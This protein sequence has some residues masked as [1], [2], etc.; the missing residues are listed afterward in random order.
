MR[1]VIFCF[2]VGNLHATLG[3]EVPYLI[4]ILS[5]NVK[6]Y[7]QLREVIK[8]GEDSR[9]LL[10]ALNEGIDNASQLLEALPIENEKVLANLA[11]FQEASDWVREV[12]GAIPK[13]SEGALFKL[14]DDT[15]SEGFK[16][17]A[18]SDNYAKIQEQNAQKVFMQAKDAS[19]KGANRG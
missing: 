7:E 3:I 15:V 17:A 12:Y 8:Q 16:M 2:L 13:S 11:K 14:H 6:R 19:P 10:M 1:I 9:Q 4:E 18:L 5:E